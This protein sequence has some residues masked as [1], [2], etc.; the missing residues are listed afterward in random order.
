M[1]DRSLRDVETFMQLLVPD[2]LWELFQ[3]VMPPTPVRPQGGEREG[4]RNIRR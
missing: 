3:R 1:S 4:G 2:E